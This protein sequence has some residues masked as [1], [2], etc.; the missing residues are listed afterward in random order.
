MLT[1]GIEGH[2]ELAMQFDTMNEIQ[3]RGG[4]FWGIDYFAEIFDAP[5]PTSDP[6][7]NEIE[8]WLDLFRTSDI[9]QI[10]VPTSD[11][12]HF[13]FADDETKRTVSSHEFVAWQ[14]FN[15]S[16]VFIYYLINKIDGQEVGQEIY[17][18]IDEEQPRSWIGKALPEYWL[19][20]A[21][22]DWLNEFSVDSFQDGLDFIEMCRS[23]KPIEFSFNLAEKVLDKSTGI[24]NQIWLEDDLSQDFDAKEKYD[25]WAVK[26]MCVAEG[27]F[28][29]YLEKELSNLF[30][31]DYKILY[32]GVRNYDED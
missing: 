22:E 5:L 8:D 20:T 12:V 23:E 31:D 32:Y 29:P 1:Q 25:D 17:P 15:A 11:K 30:M 7:G 19:S 16:S 26:V 2:L 3:R 9:G 28:F 24:C 13:C 6:N 21:Q 4:R 27:K 18:E 14:I 10:F